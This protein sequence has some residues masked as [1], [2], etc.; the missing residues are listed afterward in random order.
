[1]KPDTHQAQIVN[2]VKFIFAPTQ[3]VLWAN[4]ESLSD[5]SPYFK[6][7]FDS[8]FAESS[9]ATQDNRS[10]EADSREAKRDFDDSDD[11]TDDCIVERRGRVDSAVNHNLP[12]RLVNVDSAA[13]T[14]YHAVL[15]WINTGYIVFAPL[16]SSFRLQ[17]EPSV[18]RQAELDRLRVHPSHPLPASPKSVYRLAHYLEL[19]GLMEI[20]LAELK[21]QLTKDIL[22]Y[23][24]FG[25]V[26]LAYEDIREMELK[27]AVEDWEYIKESAAMEH[28]GKM[29]EAGELPSFGIM[30]YKLCQRV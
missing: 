10:T 19:A 16:R 17:P 3:L 5:V 14:T 7:L 27:L 21:W 4:S 11:E 23:E 13:F 20:A 25:D 29:V 30:S 22:A 24:V 9:L 12:S 8:G 1:M 28:V 2:D 15:C 18:P 6:T 26:A